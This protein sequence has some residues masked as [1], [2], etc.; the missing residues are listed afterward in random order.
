MMNQSS[1]LISG[2][3]A[4]S[5]ALAVGFGAFGAHGLESLLKAGDIT[6]RQL[7]AFETGAEYHLL[8][9]VLLVI[10]GFIPPGKWRSAAAGFI[11]AG[12]ILFS[13]SL[14]VYGL[15]GSKTA[16]MITPL[17]GLSYMIGWISLAIGVWRRV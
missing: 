1:K 10:A 15:T 11:L 8:H 16:A 3:G 2:I 5:G 4:L 14:Y 17:G 7:A 13:G 12:M 6:S 9:A